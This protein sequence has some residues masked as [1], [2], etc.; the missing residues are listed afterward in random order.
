MGG[1][2]GIQRV[3]AK[4]AAKHST[5]YSSLSAKNYLDQNVNGAK[6]G[7]PWYTQSDF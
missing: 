3:G 4:N 5:M 6:V 7:K 2:S 1:A